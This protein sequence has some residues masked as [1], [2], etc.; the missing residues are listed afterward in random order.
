MI[1]SIILSAW[2]ALSKDIATTIKARKS[3][4]NC[5]KCFLRL[6]NYV[7]IRS[8]YTVFND[9][10]WE[11]LKNRTVVQK[12]ESAGNGISVFVVQDQFAHETVYRND[13][14]AAIVGQ[15][16]CE[17]KNT[18]I[19]GVTRLSF[20]GISPTMAHAGSCFCVI[21]ESSWRVNSDANLSPYSLQM[22]RQRFI[23]EKCR[24]SN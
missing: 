19:T 15:S 21:V 14:E 6:P 24:L 4:S 2:N 5:Q 16:R 3:T 10:Q 9:F 12:L 8:I 7:L 13:P 18:A 20:I 17:R 23:T 1:M 11:H 22:T